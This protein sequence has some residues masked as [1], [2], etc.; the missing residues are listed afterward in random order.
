VKLLDIKGVAA[1]LAVSTR[2][3]ERLKKDGALPPHVLV[4]GAHRWTEESIDA[5]IR[6]LPRFDCTRKREAVRS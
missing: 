3:V 1:R 5:F 4:L 2:T 6:A